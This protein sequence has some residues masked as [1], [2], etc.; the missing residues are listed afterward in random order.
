MVPES[1]RSDE[2]NAGGGETVAGVKHVA[3][4][5]AAAADLSDMQHV[6][7]AYASPAPLAELA[8]GCAWTPPLFC[9]K[10]SLRRKAARIHKWPAIEVRDAR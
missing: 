2:R 9:R 3:E 7:D 4:R 10:M 8:L 5:R 1:R 6:G